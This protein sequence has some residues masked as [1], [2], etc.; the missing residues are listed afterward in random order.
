VSKASFVK[1][2]SEMPD[3]NNLLAEVG[4]GEDGFFFCVFASLDRLRLNHIGLAEI[5]RLHLFQAMDHLKAV[6][7]V[8][9]W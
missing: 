4:G 1:W 7:R 9:I 3:E 5:N 6:Q 2:M 8:Q